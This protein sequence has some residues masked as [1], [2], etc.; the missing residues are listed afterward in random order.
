MFSSEI[1]EF[2][3]SSLE[4]LC[5]MSNEEFNFLSSQLE[6]APLVHDPD[7]L[8]EELYS[9]ESLGELDFETFC[10]LVYLLVNMHIYCYRSG[11]EMESVVA[12]FIDTFASMAE[13]VEESKLEAVV[14]RI[15]PI[16]ETA[17]AIKLCAY[18]VMAMERRDRV[19]T[20]IGINSS[21]EP[22]F[23]GDDDDEPAAGLVNN[24]LSIGFTEDGEEKAISLC[25][26]QASLE[27]LAEQISL[28]QERNDKLLSRLARTEMAAVVV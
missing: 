6:A 20:S 22:I 12:A 14:T 7:D 1:N 16:L 26:D 13:E 3:I 23:T 4:I 19:V 9:E 8:A 2:Q 17:V 11:L 25:I 10:E 5:E 15:V 27:L 18:S 24:I 21:V 28:L